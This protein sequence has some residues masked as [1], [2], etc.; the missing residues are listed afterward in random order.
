MSEDHLPSGDVEL[1]ER[2]VRL[3]TYLRE[4]AALRLRTVR[5]I[6]QYESVLWL[7]DIPNETGCFCIAWNPTN[8]E[9]QNDYWIEIKNPHLKPAPKPTKELQPWVDPYE[10]EDSSKDAPNL[11]DKIAITSYDET[12]DG[13]KTEI[14][15]LQDFP[16]IKEQWARYVQE[17]WKPWAEIHRQQKKILKVYTDL[18]AI[19]QKQQRLGEAFEVVVGLG[20]LTWKSEGGGE[21]RRHLIVAQT[22]LT[23][24]AAAGTI[25]LGPAWSSHF[26]WSRVPMTPILAPLWRCF[27]AISA[28][29]VKQTTLIHPVFFLATLNARL[30]E[31]IG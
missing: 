22:N 4:L 2:V 30:N 15:T 12:E 25:Q 8:E 10:L 13:E 14:L 3:F 28:K 5:T 26:C 20:F 11:R 31:A 7:S 24:D 27:S 23:F 16:E 18:F 21:I 19:Y 9:E 1:R 6:E 29:R 17:K